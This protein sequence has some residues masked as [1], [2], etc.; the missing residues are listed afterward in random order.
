MGELE[1]LL[2]GLNVGGGV[3]SGGR[4]IGIQVKVWRERWLTACCN[5]G[6]QESMR[7]VRHSIEG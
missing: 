7:F 6:G 5:H 1:L 4:G 2:D 3:L